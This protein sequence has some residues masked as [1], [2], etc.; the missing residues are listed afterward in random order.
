MSTA[1]M[2]ALFGDADDSLQ[3]FLDLIVGTDAIRYWDDSIL[4][5]ADITSATYSLDYT[6]EYI[7]DITSDL[8]GYTV[9]TVPEPATLLLISLGSL[10]LHRRKR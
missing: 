6:L 7:D 8:S 1:G 5:W 2:L 4:D 10:M 3:E 9:L